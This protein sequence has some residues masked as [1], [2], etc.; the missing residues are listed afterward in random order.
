[1]QPPQDP[2]PS[3]QRERRGPRYLFFYFLFSPDTWRILVGT[4]MAVV[5][6]PRLLPV[7]RTGMGR[8]VL[9]IMITVVGWAVTGAPAR[10]FTQRLQSIFKST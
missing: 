10:W 4:I 8:Y 1:M 5:L 2:T 6:T 7:D 3:P 9:F